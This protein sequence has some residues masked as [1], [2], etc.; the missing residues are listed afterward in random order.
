[1]DNYLKTLVASLGE[2]I[3]NDPV[4]AEYLAA[5][6]EYSADAEIAG[7]VSEYNVQRMLLEEQKAAA[8][9]DETLIAS[10]EARV[11]VLYKKIMASDKMKALA[12]AENRMNELLGEVNR[13]L[14]SCIVPGS[15]CGS[16][17]EGGCGGCKGCG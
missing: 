2:A 14:M 5:K 4:A 17:H 3:K 16:G 12:V 13:E 6:E 11:N 15:G 8:E 7:A 10:I 1:M 9:R